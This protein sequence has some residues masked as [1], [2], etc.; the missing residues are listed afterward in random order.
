MNREARKRWQ[1]LK[2][3]FAEGLAERLQALPQDLRRLWLRRCVERFRAG[4]TIELALYGALV[5]VRRRSAGLT[6]PT[7]VVYNVPV[8]GGRNMNKEVRE[9]VHAVSEA[10]A[11]LVADCRSRG[12][13]VAGRDGMGEEERPDVGLSWLKFHAQ[14]PLTSD[15]R[16]EVIPRGNVIDI[17]PRPK[18]IG[19]RVASDAIPTRIA[20][21]IIENIG[22]YTALRN[23]VTIEQ[24]PVLTAKRVPI[25]DDTGNTAVFVG[26]GVTMESA[27]P[28]VSSVA[29]G[30][31]TLTSKP[32]VIHNALVRDIPLNLVKILGEILG[33]RIGRGANYYFTRGT[34]QNEPR[35]LLAN[36]GGVP[37]LATTAQ[38]DKITLEDL[39]AMYHAVDEDSRSKGV[40]VMHTQTLLEIAKLSDAHGRPFFSLNPAF[41]FQPQIFGHPVIENPHMP[42]IAPGAKVI[43]F[44]DLKRYLVR[45]RSAIRMQVLTERYASQD[46]IGIIAFY[47]FDGGLLATSNTKAIGCLAMKAQ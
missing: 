23:V 39:L 13:F 14:L 7:I 3:D 12:S 16:R 18:D 8:K 28:A 17:V 38:S 34:G 35:G 43:I 32:V 2:L 44:G 21:A 26:D 46:S 10:I 19:R 27:E 1:L 11:G 45:E 22:T 33:Q 40:W 30:C 47:D 4:H 6:L 15:E 29:F 36:N 37:T 25:F 20:E 41:H 31:Y 9:A 5:D 42:T 24:E